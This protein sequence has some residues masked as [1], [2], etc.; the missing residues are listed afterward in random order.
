MGAGTELAQLRVYQ[1]GD[2]VRQLDPAASA[3]TGV[4][5]VRL[6]VPERLM[7][8]WI[9]LDVS[10]SMAFGTGLRLKSDVAAGAA[11]LLARLAVRRGGRAGLVLCGGQ[12]ELLIPPRGG[13]RASAVI[14]HAIREGVVAD[15]A[16]D[17]ASLGRALGR[18]SRLARSPGMVAV[19]SDFRAEHGW[20]RPLRVIGG[21]HSLVAVDVSDPRRG[22]ASERGRAA[23]GRSRVRQADRGGYPRRRPAGALRDAQSTSDAQPSAT[24]CA[25]PAPRSW[26]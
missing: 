12:Q 18:L 1:P 6:H 7:T 11:A 15:G 14:E 5:H 24:N 20:A 25:R 10:P 17:D 9:V 13:R 8:A 22:G 16:G 4:P 2:D 19:V 21:R 3:R 26:S 23:P